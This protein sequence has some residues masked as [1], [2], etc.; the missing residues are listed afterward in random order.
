[1]IGQDGGSTKFLTSVLKR[2]FRHLWRWG[3][4]TALGLEFIAI[5][6]GWLTIQRGKPIESIAPTDP[7]SIAASGVSGLVLVALMPILVFSFL[8]LLCVTIGEPHRILKARVE[9]MERQIGSIATRTVPV[10][11]GRERT[12]KLLEQ[13]K[14]HTRRLLQALKGLERASKTHVFSQ[15]SPSPQDYQHQVSGLVDDLMFFIHET[16][17]VDELLFRQIARWW[18]DNTDSEG[19]IPRALYG[20]TNARAPTS[21]DRAITLIQ[22]KLRELQAFRPT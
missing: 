6:V 14:D 2:T 1:M 9:A 7:S 19:S 17:N 5:A 8:V 12:E 15:G 22:R 3:I 20:T 21:P 10:D 18:D 11:P 13:L 16:K 4:W